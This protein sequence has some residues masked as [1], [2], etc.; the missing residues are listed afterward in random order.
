[1]AGEG[2]RSC[3][4]AKCSGRYSRNAASAGEGQALMHPDSGTYSDASFFTNHSQNGEEGDDEE[5]FEPRRKMPRLDD[6]QTEQSEREANRK[7]NSVPQENDEKDCCPVCRETINFDCARVTRCCGRYICSECQEKAVRFG[8]HR[9]MHCNRNCLSPEVSQIAHHEDD[10][11]SGQDQRLERIL[12]QLIEGVAGMQQTS[13]EIRRR[14]GIGHVPVFGL[15]IPNESST[16]PQRRYPT[17]NGRYP[18]RS[19]R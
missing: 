16:P 5:D 14:Q 6:Q 2:D 15:S 17:N 12:F 8:F 9:C 19:S 13:R 11:N 18:P 1:M 4:C 10:E 7:V 3:V